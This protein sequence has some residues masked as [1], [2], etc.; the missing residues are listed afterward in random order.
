MGRNSKRRAHSLSQNRGNNRFS[1]TQYRFSRFYDEIWNT[2]NTAGETAR[3]EA[4]KAREKNS[5]FWSINNIDTMEQIS[6]FDMCEEGSGDIFEGMYT[7]QLVD[8]RRNGHGVMRYA[9]GVTYDGEWKEDKAEGCGV[10]RDDRDGENWVYEGQ[11]TND[12]RHGY[13]V[14]TMYNDDGTSKWLESCGEWRDGSIT[15]YVVQSIEGG[16][17][18]PPSTY[19]GQINDGLFHGHGVREFDDGFVVYGEF[20]DG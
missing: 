2:A 13:G 16:H 14:E 8:G 17:D 12:K 18:F 4:A 11:W 20:K 1:Q 5:E 7:G 3:E 10:Y 15:G 6:C 9:D 19:H